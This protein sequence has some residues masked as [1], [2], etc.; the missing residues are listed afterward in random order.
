MKTGTANYIALVVRDLFRHGL[1]N[2]TLVINRE[3]LKGKAKALTSEDLARTISPAHFSRIAVLDYR[4]YIENRDDLI[5]YCTANNDYHLYVYDIL[6]LRKEGVRVLIVHE[7]SLAMIATTF[8]RWNRHNSV[9]KD[10]IT[11]LT[12]Q[13]G[14]LAPRMYS[15]LYDGYVLQPLMYEILGFDLSLFQPDLTIT[16]S[17]F[18]RHK[19]ALEGSWPQNSPIVICHHP[20]EEANQAE[21]QLPIDYINSPLRLGTFGFINPSK[22]IFEVMKALAKFVNTSQSYK[23]LGRKIELHVVGQPPKSGSYDVKKKAQSLG[24]TEMTFFYG[25]VSKAELT[26][27]LSSMDII[28]NLRFPSCGETSGI[29]AFKTP[30][31][32]L[33][34]SDYHAFR[35][36]PADEYVSIDDEVNDIVSIIEQHYK[37]ANLHSPTDKSPQFKKPHP[38]VSEQIMGCLQWLR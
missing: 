26:S 27:L 2:L 5:V 28:F 36:L 16:H 24:I 12:A 3:D 4:E 22:R 37:R 29:A 17:E 6:Y 35:E 34:L 1:E 31:S 11:H 7:P 18:A 19:L 33:V 14:V 25:F 23:A 38:H 21:D 20:D 10:Y 13:F 15:D 8:F 9:S 32:S 30:R